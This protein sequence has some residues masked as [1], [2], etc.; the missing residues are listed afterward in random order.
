RLH[1]IGQRGDWIGAGLGKLWAR[2]MAAAVPPG[3]FWIHGDLHARNVL[4][5]RGRIA[6]LID[7]G[8]LTAGDVAVDLAGF[9]LLFDD[10]AARRAGLARYGA[11]QGAILRAMGW[12]MAMAVVHL[13]SGLEDHPAHA[14]NAAAVLARLDADLDTGLI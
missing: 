14:A 9:W 4:V 3:R 12:A 11:G 10:P 13:D 1:R 2:A 5:D 6:A 7:W 8:D